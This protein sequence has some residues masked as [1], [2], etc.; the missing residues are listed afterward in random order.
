VEL[1][2][3]EDPIAV[4]VPG[5]RDSEIESLARAHPGVTSFDHRARSHEAA[6]DGQ[7]ALGLPSFELGFDWIE[8]GDAITPGVQDSGKDPLIVSLGVTVPLWYGTYSDAADAERA[9][10]T[11]ARADGAAAADQAE[12]AAMVALAEVRDSARRVR[13]LEN[14]LLPQAEA[15]YEAVL[16]GFQAGRGDIARVI[17]SINALLEISVESI[18]VRADHQMA[19]A[20]LEQTVGRR[21]PRRVGQ[22]G[23]DE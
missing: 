21:L 4:G 15:A 5:V 2:T 18:E 16:G 13:L 7:A 17:L 19:W 1:P 22:E 8:T 9:E 12:G 3:T 10:A 23:R 20:R 11:A 14:T 6:A